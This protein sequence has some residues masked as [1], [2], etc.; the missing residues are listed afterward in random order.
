MY[1]K[2]RRNPPE[3]RVTNGQK[4]CTKIIFSVLKTSKYDCK[5]LKITLVQI[6]AH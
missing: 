2:L 3:V 5:I 4:P 6:F 1:E